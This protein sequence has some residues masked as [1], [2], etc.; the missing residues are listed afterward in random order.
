M[1]GKSLGNLFVRIGADTTDLKKGEADAVN[2]LKNMDAKFGQFAATALKLGAAAGAAIAA[3]GTAMV[4]SSM[5][6]AREITNLAT[7]SGVGTEE[8]R[9]LS[10]AAK[11]VG[12]EHDK[13]SDIFKDVRDRVGD[14][15]ITGAGPMADFFETVAPKIGI[16]AEAFRGLSGP[17]ALLLFKDSL[18]KANV[19]AEEQVFFMEAMAS[20]LTLLQPLLANGGAELKRLGEEASAAG[21]ALSDIETE[22]I[23]QASVAIQRITTFTAAFADQLT[24]RL[25]PILT[26]IADSLNDAAK[27]TGG[28]GS[29][30]DKAISLGVRLFASISREIYLARVGFD[31]FVGDILNGFDTLAGAMPSGLA[32][33]FGGTAEDYG[34]KPVNESWGKLRETLE[35]PMSSD[36]IEAWLA[37]VRE[38]SVAAAE[39]TIA[40]RENIINGGGMAGIGTGTD[41]GAA[42]D[43]AAALQEQMDARLEALRMSLMTEEEAERNSYAMRLIQIQEFY[44]AGMVA[45]GEYDEMMERSQQEHSERM[46]EIAQRQ[47][48]QEMALRSATLNAVASTLG[49]IGSAINSFGEKNLAAVKAFSVAQ[50]LINTYEGITKALTLP[51][52]LNW[53]QAAAVGAAG[54]AQVASIINTSKGSSG[55][56]ASSGVSAG[57][58]SASTPSQTLNLSL[59][60][61]SPSALYS[62]DQVRE[63]AQTLVQYQRDGGQLV[64]VET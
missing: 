16:T 59:Q 12:V 10:Y 9:K 60:G 19:S 35:A 46:I 62:G 34:F 2:S 1:I 25:A 55:G 48:D 49:S 42:N 18:D 40:A 63:L 29:A 33:I 17:D 58:A 39:E 53:A 7:I 13:L 21:L 8:F 41:V 51:F 14:F 44:D 43:K 15:L 30:I 24:A 64:L 45:K 38:S 26:V 28:F 31:G 32:S 57:A 37:R 56:S 3:I 52:P 11:T 50:A 61:I 22:Q 36:E 23:R 54:F 20:D 6:T 5:E 47:A 4:H 27:E